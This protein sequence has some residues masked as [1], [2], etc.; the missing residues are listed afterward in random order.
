MFNIIIFTS[1]KTFRETSCAF[2][3]TSASFANI[4]HLLANLL[5]RILISGYNIDL[6]Q[7]SSVI[8]KLHQYIAVIAPLMALSCMCFATIDQFASLTVR[9]RHFSQRHI[10]WCVVAVTLIFWCLIIIPVIMFYEVYFSSSTGSWSCSIINTNYSSYYS[11][12]YISFFTW[13]YPT[14]DSDCFWSSC[15]YKCTQFGKS[16]STN[17]PSR[18]R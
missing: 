18:T 17:Y 10:A 6:T 4:I 3:L 7:T 11:P 9:W 1:L 15:F 13:I 5:S 16:T 2:Y 12:F 14:Y 8:C